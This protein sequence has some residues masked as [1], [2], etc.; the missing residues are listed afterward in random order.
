MF[1][2]T[3]SSEIRKNIQTTSEN[4]ALRKKQYSK[5]TANK[6]M[7][8][9]D[10]TNPSSIFR[11]CFTCRV[12]HVA[13]QN[14]KKIF[15]VR[16]RIIKGPLIEIKIDWLICEYVSVC[17]VPESCSSVLLVSLLVLL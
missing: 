2:Y 17:I 11:G 6:Y 1:T 9:E 14:T 12:S 13:K 3:M 5:V 10:T 7:I 4:S 16:V 15:A 8:A